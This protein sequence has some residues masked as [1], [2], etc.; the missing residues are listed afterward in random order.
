MWTGAASRIVTVGAATTEPVMGSVPL[1]VTA[2]LAAAAASEGL[3][4]RT[5]QP[6]EVLG[7]VLPGELRGLIG[8]QA[9]GAP[10]ASAVGSRAC[11]AVK[12]AMSRS[13]RIFER[14]SSTLPTT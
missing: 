3:S 1:F 6:C 14:R 8:Q 12:A 13:A 10:D 5:L 2:T 7:E 4:A 11:V 9:G